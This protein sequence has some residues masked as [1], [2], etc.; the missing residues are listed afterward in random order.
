MRHD[1][2]RYTYD[3]INNKPGPGQMKL[4]QVVNDP[5]GINRLIL[6]SESLNTEELFLYLLDLRNTSVLQKHLPIPREERYQMSLIRS[7]KQ[8]YF[9]N[10]CKST[11][12]GVFILTVLKILSLPR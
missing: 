12:A 11:V 2:I 6:R 9:P 1:H 10:S 3:I 4:R 5:L 8:A 7:F